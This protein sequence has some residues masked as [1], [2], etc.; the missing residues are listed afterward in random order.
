MRRRRRTPSAA[1]AAIAGF[2]LGAA[3]GLLWWD[4]AMGRSSRDL[5]SRSPVRRLA[6][7]GYLAG[8]PSVETARLLADYVRWE[9]RP[10]L[11]R[12]G[13]ALLRRM[14]AFLD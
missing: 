6:A 11:R 12:R 3:I 13:Q 7:L 1:G 5:F 2:A 14:E 10:A 8:R 4:G 9:A